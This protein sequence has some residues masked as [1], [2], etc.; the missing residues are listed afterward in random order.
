MLKIYLRYACIV[1]LFFV[2]WGSAMAGNSVDTLLLHQLFEKTDSYVDKGYYD[3]AYRMADSAR[4]LAQHTQYASYYARSL[5]KLGVVNRWKG[6]LGEAL[7]LFSQSFR[8]ADS[9]NDLRLKANNLTNLGAVNRMVGNY[10]HALEEYLEALSIHMAAHNKSGIAVNYNNI[11]VVYLYL[12]DYGKALEYYKKSE[13]LSRQIGDDAGLA[14]SFINIGEVY[15]KLGKNADAIVYYMQGLDLSQKIG[16]FDSQAVL[17]SELGNIHK[18]LNDCR[19]AT[20]FYLKSLSI[21]EKL[22]DNYRLSQVLNN[23]GYCAMKLNQ[24]KQALAYFDRALTLANK[25]G[26]WELKRDANIS[27]S[28]YYESKGDYKKALNYFQE[29]TAARDSSFNK[30]TTAQLVRAQLRFDFEKDKERSLVAKEKQMLVAKEANRWQVIIRYFLIG[31]VVVLLVML[32]FLYRSYSHKK[33]LSQIL[34]NHEKEILEKNEELELQQEEILAQRDQIEEKNVI[35]Q[36]HQKEIEAQNE[37]MISSLEYAQTIQEAILPEVEFFEKH[38]R[39]HFIIYRPKDIVSGDFYWTYHTENFIY[40]A[41]ADCTGHGVPGG[42][43][44]MIG[45]TLINQLVIEYQMSNPAKILEELNRMIRKA[46]KQNEVSAR[47]YAGMDIAFCVV[48]KAK[49]K[50]YFAGAKRPLYYFKG[51]EFEKIAGDSR[52]V[53][54]Y[55]METDRLFTLQ[56]IDLDE[57]ITLYLFTDGYTDQLNLSERKYGVARFKEQLAE[58]H[59]LP[60]ARQMELLIRS[61]EEFKGGN[62]QIDDITIIGLTL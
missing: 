7:S 42:F 46:L 23:L 6:N 17:F 37:R 21:F 50:L 8:I 36:I 39:N 62:E 19:F 28:N 11:G 24:R 27:L 55:Q 1:S 45:N 29:H 61:H 5:N 40:V 59:L 10:S 54:G 51:N 9:L 26:S 4:I 53:G 41:L 16:D 12:G 30:E 44:S 47:S 13:A 18:S 48:D 15:Q 56:T 57:P 43:M 60:M 3:S 14:I 58:I 31:I 25:V 35:L 22:G 33:K 49:K 38:F 20:D 2:Q 52:S 34:L 32:A